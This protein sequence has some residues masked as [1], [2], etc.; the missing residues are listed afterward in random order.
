MIALGI[1]AGIFAIDTCIKRYID[2]NFSFDREKYLF[3]KR[4]LIQKYY[5]KGAVLNFLADFPK[6]MRGIHAGIFAVVA[7]M[8]VV[9]L[10]NK[11]NTGLK[12]ALGLL[13]GGGASNLFDRI[14]KG[15]VVDYF[16]FVTPFRK[17]NEIV[18]N[19]S[20]IAIFIGAVLAVF[21]GARDSHSP[22]GQL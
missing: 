15:H 2:K 4:I 11:G 5:N 12:L 13:A 1:P 8:Y 19:L 21:F 6:V 7:G 14:K 3:G 10:K 20:D 16:S 9:L 18:F 17:F 22:A